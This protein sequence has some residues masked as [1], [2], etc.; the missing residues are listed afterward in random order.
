MALLFKARQ[1]SLENKEGKKQWYPV[2]VKIGK[3]V[4]LID[5]SDEVSEK[6]SL[7]PGD[8]LSAARNLMKV[9]SRHLLNSRSVRLDGLGTFTVIAKA[10]GTG[11]DEEKDVSAT[12]IN[13]LRI[14]FT[15]EFTR[16]G[17]EGVTRAMFSKVEYA[18]WGAGLKST[19]D[20]GST[21]GG[22]G[23]IDPDA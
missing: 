20:S 1:S 2:L 7:T 21:G 18:K 8:T 12:Q 19:Q 9:M 5:M 16:N 10:N 11:V 17:A 13:G 4:S 15:P 6:S 22:G 23:Q 3:P 14:R